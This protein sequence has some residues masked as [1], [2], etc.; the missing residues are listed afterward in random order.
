MRK[1]FHG[2]RQK[3]GCVTLVMACVLA[4]SWVRS[5]VAQE[6]VWFRRQEI[7]HQLRHDNGVLRWQWD[8]MNDDEPMLGCES[9]EFTNTFHG[10][11]GGRQWRFSTASITAP[12]W[13]LV[14]PLTI[15]SAYLLLW[16]PRKR[17]A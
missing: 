15:L 4:S 5:Y 8:L 13:A 2:W 9:Y 11:E 10:H 17:L 3:M 1:F 14:L 12:H 6:L 16:K 7:A